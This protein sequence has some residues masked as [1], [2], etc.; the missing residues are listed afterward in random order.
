MYACTG[1][2]LGQWIKCDQSLCPCPCSVPVPSAAVACSSRWHFGELREEVEDIHIK[3][4]EMGLW[5]NLFILWLQ[6]ISPFSGFIGLYA[7]FVNIEVRFI[8]FLVSV[9]SL[10][11]ETRP[12]AWMKPVWLELVVNKQNN[13]W[14]S[15][16][17]ETC[18]GNL[19]QI[20]IHRLVFSWIV[21]FIRP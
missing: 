9:S 18:R 15:Q 14:K 3:C 17:N 8:S 2:F 4:Y 6:F 19:K 13:L 7:P 5:S 20:L 21:R 1:Y 16:N 11:Y 10:W 12:P